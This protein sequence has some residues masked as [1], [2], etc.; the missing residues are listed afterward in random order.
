[1]SNSLGS[2][3]LNSGSESSA[4]SS[5]DRA[6]PELTRMILWEVILLF[7]ENADTEA[8][9]ATRRRAREYCMVANYLF[10]WLRLCTSMILCLHIWAL[11]LHLCCGYPHEIGVTFSMADVMWC[12]RSVSFTNEVLGC[13]LRMRSF[14]FCSVRIHDRS[15]AYTVEISSWRYYVLFSVWFLSRV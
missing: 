2:S 8:M 10:L 12:Y 5:D 11:S 6:R 14:P 15:T 4:M 7:R 3:G 9:I 1:M 13:Y